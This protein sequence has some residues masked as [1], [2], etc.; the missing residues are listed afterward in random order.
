MI[1][2]II[3]LAVQFAVGLLA[4][5]WLLGGIAAAAFFVGREITQAEY[6]WIEAFGDGKRENMPWW[7]GFDPAVWN[8]KSI[9]DAALPVIAVVILFAVVSEIQR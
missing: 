6:R 2:A 8:L 3:T 1:H 5:N 7:G 9:A 4:G